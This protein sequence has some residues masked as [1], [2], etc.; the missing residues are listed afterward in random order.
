MPRYPR[1][2]GMAGLSLIELMIAMV[3]GLLVAAGIISVF[4][5]T[6]SSN[7]VQSQLAELQETGRFAISR[8]H[9]DLAMANGLYCTNNG[10]IATPQTA[11][12]GTYLDG[13]RSPMVYAK[14]LTGSMYDV[15]TPMGGS[16]GGNSY[17]AVPAAKYTFPSFLAMRGYDCSTTACT[18]VDPNANITA[19]PV[20]GTALNN[21]V[22]GTDVLT[23]RYVNPGRGWLIGAGHS[24]IT[25]TSA[26]L[27]S[28]I[29]LNPDTAT[30]EPPASD[31]KTGDLAMLAD[32]SNAQIF[33]AD[34][35]S[36]AI[37]PNAANNFSTPAVQQ[38]SSAP[39]VYDFNRDFQTVT[40]YLQLVSINNN[41]VA[42]FTGALMRRVNGGDINHG[43]SVDEIAR[44]IERMDFLYGVEGS[45]GRTR[46]LTAAQVDASTS[47]D[48][49]PSAPTPL[50][51]TDPGCLW[52]SV[53]SIEVSL[54]VD[55]LNPL[56]T[57]TSNDLAYVYSV[58]GSNAAQAPSAHTIKPTAQGFV[59][60][61][62]RRQF[63]ALIAVRNY[64][65]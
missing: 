25:G 8:M 27:L 48:C 40:Y 20:M 37:T 29:T 22:P 43:G 26:G 34:Y 9:S 1:R 38:P 52:R 39:R 14:S 2:A 63:T 18:P 58:D 21:R 57:L 4:I 16:S 7:K 5:S 24:T 60:P 3:L 32:C 62:L 44:G 6:S 12:S 41:N 59:N 53:K 47:A 30:D 33:A 65:P 31:F 45:D 54:L 35:G 36:G 51:A 56:Y 46:F 17:P 49:P 19:I 28:S 13:L 23:I 50:S 15:T 10:G 42:P 64:N 61:L 55:G 11:S